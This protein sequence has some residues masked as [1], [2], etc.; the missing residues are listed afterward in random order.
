MSFQTSGGFSIHSWK[1]KRDKKWEKE[2]LKDGHFTNA[3]NPVHENWHGLTVTNWNG[4]TVTP[5]NVYSEKMYSYCIMYCSPILYHVNYTPQFGQRPMMSVSIRKVAD[6]CHRHFN[7][8]VVTCPV[9]ISIRVRQ[10]RQRRRDMVYLVMGPDPT[11][12][13]TALLHVK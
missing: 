2:R 1:E 10:W 6:F 11:I 8:T 12:P 3:K 13:T 4:R 5:H 7:V 9:G